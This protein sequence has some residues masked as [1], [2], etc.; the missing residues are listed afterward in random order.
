MGSSRA[1][2]GRTLSPSKMTY[3]FAEGLDHFR[4][5]VRTAPAA[6]QAPDE[7]I[8]NHLSA[9]LRDFEAARSRGIFN[10]LPEEAPGDA[11]HASRVRTIRSRLACLGYLRHDSGL[12]INDPL[13][14]HAIRNFQRDAGLIEDGWVGGQTWQALQELVGFEGRR[15]IGRWFGDHDAR[16]ALQRAIALRLHVLGLTDTPAFADPAELAAG[17]HHFQAVAAFLG[18][19]GADIRPEVCRDTISLLFNQELLIEKLADAPSP[20][21]PAD[22][23]PLFAFAAGVAKV[24][25]WLAG[26]EVTPDGCAPRELFPSSP[27]KRKGR[28]QLVPLGGTPQGL[29]DDS[30]LVAALS[31]YWQDHGREQDAPRLAQRFTREFAPFFRMIAAAVRTA[32][33]LTATEKSAMIYQA[34]AAQPDRLETIWQTAQG[35]GGQMWDGMG[36]VIGWLHNLRRQPGGKTVGIGRNIARLVYHQ[37]MTAYDAVRRALRD[38]PGQLDGIFQRQWPGS[39]P[40]HIVMRHDRDLDFQVYINPRADREKI[41]RFIGAVRQTSASFVIT[42]RIIA[43]FLSTL[44]SGISQGTAGWAGLILTLLQLS[45]RVNQLGRQPAAAPAPA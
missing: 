6:P 17:L 7:M 28:Q 18:L 44:R 14:T 21:P 20:L 19:A 24:E 30:P 43:V 25:L 15:D 45:H 2:R 13:L 10:P 37:A 36:R 27:R 26:Y 32:Q 4:Q 39:D 41:S 40:G 3:N 16:P 8:F 38:F 33:S 9:L 29:R 35:L 1:R 23:H 12:S 31:S 34:V 11:H 22:G 42:C 5:T